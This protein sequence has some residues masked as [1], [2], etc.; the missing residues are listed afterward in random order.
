VLP[1]S[2]VFYL[3]APPREIK[4]KKGRRERGKIFFGFAA[5]LRLSIFMRNL[6][7][8]LKGKGKEKNFR[9][10][11]KGKGKREG[12]VLPVLFWAAS[13][14]SLSPFVAEQSCKKRAWRKKRERKGRKREMQRAFPR[15]C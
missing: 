6:K 1:N 15:E 14:F 3:P 7:K 12:A 11:R 5:T 8:M 13:L 9:K 2:R 10:K 4:W